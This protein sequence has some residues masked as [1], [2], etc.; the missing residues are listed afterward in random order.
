MSEI[1]RVFVEKK[2]GYDIEAGH[3]QDHI[4]GFLGIE[5]AQ[6]VRIVHCYDVQ[7]LTR[8]QFDLCVQK[9]LAEANVD[10]VY[11]EVSYEADNFIFGKALLPGQY[12]QRA[13]W[14]ALSAQV[15][16]GQLPVVAYTKF[17]IISG[18]ITDSQKQSVINYVVNPVDSMQVGLDKPQ[19]LVN[20]A[21]A[22]KDVEDVDIMYRT[23]DELE[24]V[25]KSLGM[26]MS[27]D[28]F[29]FLRDYF[30]N[31]ENRNPTI[32]EVKMIDTYWSDHCRHTT[33]NTIL[34]GITFEDGKYKELFEQTYNH[35]LD[36]R[37]RIYTDD[38]P[39]SL[40]D[41]AVIGMKALRVYGYL[42]DL[43]V[44]EEI[45]ACSIEIDV[46]VEGEN[47]K[48]LLMFKN[49]THNHPTEIEP[50]GGAATCLGGAIRDPL[51]GRS[52][53][54]QAMRVTGSG[55]PRRALSETL[56][57][58]LPQ[59]LITTQ[60]AAG[61]SSYGNQ[62]G[63]AT[64]LV[65]EIYHEGYIA[66]RME[67]GAVIGAVKKENVIRK[68]PQAGDVVLLIGGRT[69]RD[70][71]GGATGSSKSHEEHS[72]A[73]AG[74]EVQKGNPV[75]QRKIQRLFRNPEA[76]K[77]IIRCNDFGAGGVS[78]AIGE[79]ADSL[80]VNLDTI[81]KKYDGLD[82]TELAISES[83]ERM[84]VVVHKKDVQALIDLAF[85]ENLEA[86]EVA[87]I[88]DTGRLV[89]HWRNKKIVDISRKFLNTSGIKQK[90]KAVVQSP[91]KIDFNEGQ[92]KLS[93][94]NWLANLGGLNTASQQ[95]LAENFD[96]SVGGNTILAPFGGKYQLT[97]TQAMAA[98]VPVLGKK[99]ATASL[100]SFGFDPYVSEQSPYHGAVY[101]VVESVARLVASGADY[102]KIRLS[103][104]EYF[105]RMT[106]AEVWGKPVAA[107]L[108]AYAAQM[109]LGI[110]AIGGKDSMSGTFENRLHVPPTLISFSATAMPI[111]G[112]ASP[113][114]KAAGNTIAILKTPN[115]EHSLPDF[116]ALKHN[117]KLLHKQIAEGKIVSAYV[118]GFGGIAAAVSQ[119]AFG[120]KIGADIKY[121]GDFFA[122]QM[123]TFVV[124]HVGSDDDLPE[125]FEI[126]GLTTDTKTLKIN[127]ISIDIDECINVWMRPLEEIFPTGMLDIKP[128]TIDLPQPYVSKNIAIAKEKFAKPKVFVPV[129]PGT[130][131]EW[132][133]EQGFKEAGAVVDLLVINNLTQEAF[134][135]SIK[136][137]SQKIMQ[138]QIIAIPGGF[139]AGDE[140][141]G[142]AKFIAAVFSNP[143]IAEATM[144]LIDDRKGLMIGIC[145]GF[146]ALVKLGLLPYGKIL[147]IGE[148][149]PTLT[150]NSIGRHISNIAQTK[151]MSNKSPWLAG[152][153]TG[154]IHRMAM[155]HGQGRFVA[156]PQLTQELFANGQVS[157]VYVDH[158]GNATENL[159]HNP[160]GSFMGIEG[161]TDPTGRI[162]GKMG[163]NERGIVFK[164]IPGNFDQKLFVSGVKYFG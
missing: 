93:K 3:L 57:G 31:G 111:A 64:G 84:G 30:K 158:N 148:D 151:V 35:Y 103:F 16:T 113:E 155:S 86:Y 124:E 106:T 91:E 32:T 160:N 161:I 76:A 66:K 47:E 154:D 38:R 20:D 59:R 131:C 153:Q 132:D 5:K 36:T 37:N 162:F 149:F 50:F 69:G 39:I 21:P 142:S 141:E 52:Y 10:N 125:G 62:I 79:L 89:M 92:L 85:A 152:V 140:P 116:E 68:V 13:D 83:Q 97:P 41:M 100:M 40:M 138:S 144:Q 17:H 99:S 42:D 27:F 28:D 49:E 120:N 25:Y 80:D 110:A 105:Q 48:W 117:F 156:S 6:K 46:D 101:A 107:L 65:R 63:L 123:G 109:G 61:Y 98:K 150:Y 128:I 145:N 104:Q 90:T 136:Q 102:E 56:D 58:K 18:K 130:N 121:D 72:L 112:I 108:G 9:V 15:L 43:D 12:D 55:D 23:D 126:L 127:D 96:S 8:A 122:K 129:F 157:T 119:M 45:N 1:Y 139:S 147:P 54:Y 74:A 44:S 134:E 71:V 60:A 67:V 78:V 159:P 87:K 19:T 82:G 143:A 24:A 75:T 53:V 95:G 70:G 115:N 2:A 135:N 118:V 4:T 14:A 88:T 11:D 22:P 33:F 29:S 34:E 94:A 73:T 164:N 163:H 114:F 137:M 7:G 77:L 26:A 51:S 146:Q 81:L 133:V